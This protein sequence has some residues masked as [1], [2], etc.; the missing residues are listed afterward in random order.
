MIFLFLINFGFSKSYKGAE[1]RTNETFTYGRFEVRYK[2]PVGDGFLA[3]FFTYHD[4]T[5][6]IQNWN[7]IDLEI[8]GRYSDNIQF[9][10]I[11]PGQT[12]HE[13]HQYVPFNPHL[14]FH[15]YGF[16][17]TP[18]Y[19]AWF[20]DGE[21]LYRQTGDHIQTLIHEQKLMM[22]I[23]IPEYENWA[24]VWNPKLLPKFAYY[25]WVSYAS[26][27]PGAGNTGTN[28]NFSLQ[29]K[30]DFDSWDT[31]RWSKASHT[32][33]GNATDFVPENVAFQNGKMIL[34]LTNDDDLGLVDNIPPYVLWARGNRNKINLRFSEAV[35]TVSALKTSSY[36]INRLIGETK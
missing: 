28:Q 26:Y 11:T 24:G 18:D 30:D 22:N 29:W 16:E 17:W 2:P 13:S 20:V 19:V 1:L 34:C 4:F 14:G 33:E 27:T 7:E 35:D 5:N 36:V 3:S 8:M 15:T 31:N 6:G 32:W 12:N 10:T 9:N 25:D 23:W 21:E